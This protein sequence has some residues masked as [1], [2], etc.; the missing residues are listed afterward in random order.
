MT[1]LMEQERY[2]VGEVFS[3]RPPTSGESAPKRGEGLLIPILCREESLHE[4]ERETLPA[5][6][7]VR[8]AN[9]AWHRPC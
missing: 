7:S 6:H 8:P 5:Q 3:T 2:W 1:I 4:G 9:G